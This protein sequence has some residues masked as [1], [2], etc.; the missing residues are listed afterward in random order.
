MMSS[1][2]R[3]VTAAVEAYL[4]VGTNLGDRAANM[5]AAL[6]GIAEIA[7]V[8]AVSGI[9][10]SAPFG[11]PDQP[12]FWNLAV[13]VRTELQARD[14]MHALQKIE[15]RVGRTPTFRMGPRIVDIDILLYGDESIDEPG[16]CVPHPGLL[17]RAF[18]VVPLLDLD[19]NLSDPMS[20]ARL[21][22]Q[23]FS[24]AVKRIGNADEV[25]GARA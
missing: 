17:E 5:R 6:D 1:G 2:S 9:Y 24:S 3:T 18:V 12:D 16:L 15:T 25:L 8:D 7:T 20:G 22:N 19:A 21:A 23:T 11:Y 10:E 4:G 13:R 14:L